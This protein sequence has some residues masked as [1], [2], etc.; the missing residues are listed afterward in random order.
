M[1]ET[2]DLNIHF[3]QMPKVN[4]FPNVDTFGR[5]CSRRSERTV[6]ENFVTKEEEE[7]I[8]QNEQF[9]LLTQCF[10]L[11][12]VSMSSYREIF[13]FIVEMFSKLSTA[14]FLYLG[15]G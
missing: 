15:K 10:Q 11:C 7:E 2:I 4:P 12:S 5:L 13:H 14:D 8:A 3:L 1:D 6:F 9:L